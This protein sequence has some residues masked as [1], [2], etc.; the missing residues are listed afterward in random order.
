MFTMSILPLIRKFNHFLFQTRFFAIKKGIAFATPYVK[1]ISIL[2]DSHAMPI[3]T[4][5]VTTIACRRGSDFNVS[6]IVIT[7]YLN[8]SRFTER[9]ITFF[10]LLLHF[11]FSNVNTAEPINKSID[12]I[13]P[14]PTTK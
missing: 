4:T 10:R 5:P 6:S 3:N 2:S 1:S 12:N 9:S 7:S 8:C 11:F 13:A 14:V